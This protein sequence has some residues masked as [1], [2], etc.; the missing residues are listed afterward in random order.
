LKK[1]KPLPTEILAMKLAKA[2][3]KLPQGTSVIKLQEIAGF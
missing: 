2:P 3:W 1:Y